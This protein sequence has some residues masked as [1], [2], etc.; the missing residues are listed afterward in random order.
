[1]KIFTRLLD[2]Q[3]KDVEQELSELSIFANSEEIQQLIDFLTYVKEDHLVQH[4]DNRI[5]VTHSHFSMWKGES[6]DK[7]DLQI[8]STSDNW[9]TSDN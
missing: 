6:V 5:A 1:M 8:W 9:T 7:P 2:N 3:G 4:R